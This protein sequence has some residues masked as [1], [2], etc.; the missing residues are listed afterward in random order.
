VSVIYHLT[1]RAEWERALKEG[2]LVSES[3]DTEGFIHCSTGAQHAASANKHFAGRDDLML[4]LVDTD[5][6]EAQI[7]IENGFPH[8]YGALNADAVFEAVT[9]A[10]GDDGR[11]E[12]HD[13]SIGFETFGGWHIEDVERR[14]RDAMNGYAAPWGVAGGW[15]IALFL[16]AR[17]RP[18]ADVEFVVRFADQRALFDHL[19]DWDARLVTG[20]GIL[21]PWHGEPVEPNNQVWAR[22]GGAPAPTWREFAADTTLIDF[23]FEPGDGDE[24]ICRR[25]ERIRLP[26]NDMLD[27]TECGVPFVRPEIVLLFKAKH[28]RRKDQRDFDRVLPS[29]CEPARAWLADALQIAHPGHQWIEA[30]R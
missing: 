8:I 5:C 25:D 29:L 3:L 1:S 20:Y 13:E 21:E 14:A 7:K 30:L 6:V 26:M 19:R 24:W 9:Y 4:L 18:H 10:P 22:T 17:G 27:T 12:Q 16:G 15:A 2:E 23:L 11:F 28:A